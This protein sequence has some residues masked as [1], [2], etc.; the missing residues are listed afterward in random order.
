M[1]NFGSVFPPEEVLRD[2][3][4]H[5]SWCRR[6]VG[7]V[8]LVPRKLFFSDLDADMDVSKNRGKTPKMDGL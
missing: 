3:L 2:F 1:L 6:D 7:Y 8:I 5:S 4:I